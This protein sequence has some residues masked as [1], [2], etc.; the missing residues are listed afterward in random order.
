MIGNSE[1]AV[2]FPVFNEIEI[3]IIPFYYH[4]LI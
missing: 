4:L 2:T 1:E 3:T